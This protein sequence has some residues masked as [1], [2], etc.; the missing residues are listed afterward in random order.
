MTT[1]PPRLSTAAMTRSRPTASASVLRELEVGLAVLEERRAGDD[2]LRAGGEHLLRALDGADAAADAARERAGD[3]PDEREVVAGAHR[4]V[5]VDHLHLR[6]ALEPP[7]PAEDVLVP[8][9]EALALDELH[10]GAALGDRW[11]E[12][13]SASARSHR[14]HDEDHFVF[15]GC[16]RRTRNAALL[17][18]LLE[19]PHAGFR[20]VKDRRR[21]RGVGAAG[22]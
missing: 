7:H 1:W 10:D 19:R 15:A 14:M 20:V 8:D 22:R 11:R 9:R 21:E 3:L 4:G 16:H 13:A 2:L 18:M 12:S 17:K 6:E 5:E